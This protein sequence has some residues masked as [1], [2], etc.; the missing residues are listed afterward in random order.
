MVHLPG[1]EDVN[2]ELPASSEGHAVG[3]IFLVHNPTLLIGQEPGLDR[4]ACR[5][6]PDI[7]PAAYF[8][9]LFFLISAGADA[10]APTDHRQQCFTEHTALLR[11]LD[12]GGEANSKE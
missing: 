7:S 9:D 4:I 8:E 2:Q 5:L 10:Q 6:D 11:L 1:A 12:F 3:L